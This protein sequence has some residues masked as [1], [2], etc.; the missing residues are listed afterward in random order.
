[1]ESMH[2]KFAIIEQRL[3]DGPWFFGEDWSAVD[4]YLFWVWFRLDGTGFDSSAY[5][6]FADHYARMQGRPSVRKAMAIEHAA[7]Q[8]LKAE[9][10]IVN[11]DT[12][13][14]GKTPEDFLAQVTQ[15][16][17]DGSSAR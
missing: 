12:F 11:F 16:Q 15:S 10:L 7:G 9:G 13:R 4:A 1:M 6:A 5:P 17:S 14:P 8:K 2:T 3:T